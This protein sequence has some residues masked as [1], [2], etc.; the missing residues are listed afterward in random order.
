GISM[1]FVLALLKH[2]TNT[3]S[4]QPTTVQSFS[5]GSSCEGPCYGADA[6]A[7]SQGTN[8]AVAAYLDLAKEM[9]AE[10][11]Y[12]VYANAVPSGIVTRAAFE[13]LTQPIIEAAAAGCDAI[14]LDLHGAM[15]AE[16][17]PDAEGELLRRVRA[18]QPDVPIAVALDFHANIS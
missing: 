14:L 4:A 7:V 18:V 1:R 13:T 6:V 9:N 11:E 10:V 17:Y 15:V 5:R 16:G 2:E 12:A 3:F 8:S